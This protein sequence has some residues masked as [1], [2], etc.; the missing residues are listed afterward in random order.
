MLPPDKELDK[1][2]S[3]SNLSLSTFLKMSTDDQDEVLSE[4][5]ARMSNL[6]KMSTSCLPDL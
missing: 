3:E 4:L 5:H 6:V 2:L 1:F